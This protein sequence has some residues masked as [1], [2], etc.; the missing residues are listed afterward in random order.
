MSH[1]A[2]DAANTRS[3]H[4]FDIDWHPARRCPLPA[5]AELAPLQQH[6]AYAAALTRASS[7][8]VHDMRAALI[9][10]GGRVVG[11]AQLL[12]RHLPVLGPVAY[13]PRG[14][15]WCDAV[16]ESVKHQAL[17]ALRSSLRAAG[18]SSRIWLA[19]AEDAVGADH[20]ARIG[21]LPVITPQHVAEIDLSGDQD[22]RLAAQHGKWRN[23]LRHAQTQALH[24][25]HRRLNPAQD[26]W[27]L[28]AETVQQGVKG[29]RALPAA[30]AAQYPNDQTRLFLA[31]KR[32][33]V[34]AAMLILRHGAA[35]S[36]HIGWS[37][38]AGRS[39]SAHN[40]LLWQASNWLARKGVLRFDLGSVDTDGAAG[41]ARFKLGAGADLRALGP[42][43]L[44]TPSVAHLGKIRGHLKHAA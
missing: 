35:A 17:R 37:S 38:S 9:H 4:K 1:R 23:R 27:L 33:E 18:V 15:L 10:H 7:A 40:L 14:P 41:L 34:I 3:D 5:G 19:N 28:A 24:V 31:E 42:T 39:A 25:A 2:A 32:G 20:L 26:G 29:Y 11:R 16:P 43:M 44:Y 22:T 6:P 8:S 30:F 13:L 21:Y 12:L 36:Y